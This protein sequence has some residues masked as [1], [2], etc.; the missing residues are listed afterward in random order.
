MIDREKL[1]EMRAFAD[2]CRED[3]ERRELEDPDLSV[4]VTREAPQVIRKITNNATEVMERTSVASLDSARQMTDDDLA[5][6][7]AEQRNDMRKEF[8]ARIAVLEA[9]IDTLVAVLGSDRD[10]TRAR[11]IRARKR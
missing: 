10:T 9:R 2:E 8:E 5:W 1:R 3:L 11:S 6:A 4:P 7:F